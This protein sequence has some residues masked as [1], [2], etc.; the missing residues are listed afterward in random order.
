MEFILQSNSNLLELED[1]KLI[2]LYLSLNPI[3]SLF[4]FFIY[5]FW[6]RGI[7]NAPLNIFYLMSALRNIAFENKIKSKSPPKKVRSEHTE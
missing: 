7:T 1:W 4:Q 5:I 6:F 3:I 2:Y